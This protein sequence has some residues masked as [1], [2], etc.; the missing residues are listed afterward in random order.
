MP[1]AQSFAPLTV[2]VDNLHGLGPFILAGVEV[3]R[4]PV[5]AESGGL[6]DPATGPAPGCRF[7]RS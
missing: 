1:P 4:L 6:G 5:S 7:P 3:D 2:T